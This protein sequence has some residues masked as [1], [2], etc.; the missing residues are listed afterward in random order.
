[1]AG[2]VPASLSPVF[3]PAYLCG[4]CRRLDTRWVL[5]RPDLAPTVADACLFTTTP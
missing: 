4:M 3:S 1:V 2:A 5:T